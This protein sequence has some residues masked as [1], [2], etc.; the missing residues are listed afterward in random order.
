MISKLKI[1]HIA[2]VLIVGMFS[3]NTGIGQKDHLIAGNDAFKKGLYQKAL[4]D[5]KKT[6]N[7][8]LGGAGLY[9][10]TARLTL[11]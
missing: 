10:N 9:T 7:F 3:I 11:N 8:G 2:L 1:F 4:E 5:Y 6:E